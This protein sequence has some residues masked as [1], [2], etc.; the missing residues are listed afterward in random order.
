MQHGLGT[1]SDI[2]QIGQAEDW[3]ELEQRCRNVVSARLCRLL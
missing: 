1:D 2:G 3:R